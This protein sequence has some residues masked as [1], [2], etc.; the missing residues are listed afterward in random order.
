MRS[1]LRGIGSGLL[2]PLQSLAPESSVEE[3]IVVKD[4][5]PDRRRRSACR[6]ALGLK[7]PPLLSRLH[8]WLARACAT[9]RP[10]LAGARI[11][12]RRDATYLIIPLS[13]SL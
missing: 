10:D 2:L 7:S 5:F 11:Q 1:S 9:S 3:A 4:A 8:I 12:Q 13:Q 6:S